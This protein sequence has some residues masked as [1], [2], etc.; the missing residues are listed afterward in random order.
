MK[1]NEIA[2]VVQHPSVAKEQEFRELAHGLEAAILNSE[3]TDED[4]ALAERAVEFIMDDRNSIARRLTILRGLDTILGDP[5][6]EYT[7]KD[8]EEF[9]AD[10]DPV[11][12]K[13]GRH[14][15][16][17]EYDEDIPTGEYEV[18]STCGGEGCEDCEEGLIDVTGQYEIPK[19]DT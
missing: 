1:I 11:P 2:D 7:M 9:M 8:L 17:V 5:R 4:D 16:V 15:S 3:F 13:K 14:L 6:E 18:C 19:F 10:N 12:P